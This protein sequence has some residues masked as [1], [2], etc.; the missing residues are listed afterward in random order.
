[1]LITV[2]MALRA[3]MANALRTLLSVLGIVIGISCVVALM[4]IGEGQRQEMLEIFEYFGTN[5]VT[6]WPGGRGRRMSNTAS[7]RIRFKMADVEYVL[8]NAKTI[9]EISPEANTSGRVKHLNNTIDCSVN[10]VTS[11]FFIVENRELLEGRLIGA[12]DVAIAARVVVLGFKAAENLFGTMSAIGSSVQIDGKA[13]TVIGVLAEKGAFSSR[14]NPDEDVFVPITTNQRRLIGSNDVH[15]FV[16][17]TWN[18]EDTSAAEEEVAQLLGRRL[19]IPP[20]QED[21]YLGIWNSGERQQEREKTART[22]RIFL[23]IVAAI[24]LLIGGIGIMNIMLVSVTE[25]TREIG[26]R[27]A[28]GAKKRT[29]LAQFLVESLLVCI[30]GAIVGVGLALIIIK[31]MQ[32]LPEETEF[33][34]PLLKLDFILIAVGISVVIALIFGIFPAARAASLKPIDALRHE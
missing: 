14:W 4:S 1:M 9:K 34:A 10:G 15:S 8:E 2:R 25:R 3:L 23:M 28:L 12:G 19:N 31:V 5:Q 29:I 32:G 27:K 30:F 13:F 26:L 24:A 20:G 16:V 18:V 11:S 17:T 33:P 7:K 21:E 6:V 22:I